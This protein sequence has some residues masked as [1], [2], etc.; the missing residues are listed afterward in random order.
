M[1]FIYIPLCKVNP[2]TQFLIATS[3]ER[4]IER[5]IDILVTPGNRELS[6]E[7][8]AQ[9]CTVV[10]KVLKQ[11][12]GSIR[13]LSV[14][15]HNMTTIAEILPYLAGNAERLQSLNLVVLCSD[16]DAAFPV[17]QPLQLMIKA[18]QIRRVEVGSVPITVSQSDVS[19]AQELAIRS[20]VSC[21]DRSC[22]GILHFA[23]DFYRLRRLELHDMSY[24][25]K[26]DFMSSYFKLNTAQGIRRTIR[27][28]FLEELA[29]GCVDADFIEEVLI[30]IEA[31]NLK[32][33]IITPNYSQHFSAQNE[34]RDKFPRLECVVINNAS[35][36]LLRCIYCLLEPKDI[37]LRH[38]ESIDDILLDLSS[39]SRIP[40]CKTAKKM[41]IWG[42][43]VSAEKLHILVEIRKSASCALRELK[44]HT[45]IDNCLWG[46]RSWFQENVE[47]F[48]WETVLDLA[49]LEHNRRIQLSC[50]RIKDEQKDEVL[51][52]PLTVIH[53]ENSVF[54]SY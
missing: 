5:G 52:R 30:N 39:G 14:V 18:P 41:Q 43:N 48:S 51:S 19:S 20:R 42:T 10:F 24:D 4:S 37:Y 25:F 12:I 23:A 36:Q 11:F 45:G 38:L 6:A 2:W 44:V 49:S 26:L 15:V 40:C 54:W 17:L 50:E 3:I 33:V 32:K 29:L 13:N 8:E 34:L 47:T 28:E 35:P 46:D 16:P 21:I 1:T 7:L 27:F 31:P 53:R 22:C 9:C